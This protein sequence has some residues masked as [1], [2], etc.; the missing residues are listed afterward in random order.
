ML[1][2]CCFHFSSG[3]WGVCV[4]VI[5]LLSNYTDLIISSAE[6]QWTTT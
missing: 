5:E 1:S 3:G 6:V 2:N 4:C